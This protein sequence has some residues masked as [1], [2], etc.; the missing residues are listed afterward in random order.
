M[1]ALL[2]YTVLMLLM[3]GGVS[4][5]TGQIID[6]SSSSP[7]PRP[8]DDVPQPVLEQLARK[9]SDEE[10]REF[11]ELIDNAATASVLATEIRDGFARN[12]RLSGDDLRRIDK[13][14]RITR[15]IRGDLGGSDDSV[16]EN[17][18]SPE[19]PKT[20][21]DA[22]KELSETAATMS[23]EVSRC[24][25]YSVS[26]RSIELSNRVLDLVSIIRKIH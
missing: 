14:E 3:T 9:K 17:E 2:R 19:P 11:K 25:R 8:K 23:A 10:R 7:F 12:G 20:L 5:C 22:V 6:A 24:T 15:Q 18:S 4:V 1:I 26:V 16:S 13:L 21:G